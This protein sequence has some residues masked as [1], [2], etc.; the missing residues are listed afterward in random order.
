MRLRRGKRPI[1][2]DDAPRDGVKTATSGAS[3]AAGAVRVVLKRFRDGERLE[4][5]HRG[6]RLERFV[7]HERRID[8]ARDRLDV[9]VE[10]ADILVEV[11]HFE[12]GAS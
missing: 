2:P 7:R 9:I 3:V 10:H 11:A 4:V 1:G 8:L 12:R 5:V 6:G